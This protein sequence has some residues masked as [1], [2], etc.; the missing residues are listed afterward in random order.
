MKYPQFILA[1]LICLS[2]VACSTDPKTTDPIN[3]Q[4]KTP[5]VGQN[6]KA[7]FDSNTVQQIPARE[8]LGS[9]NERILRYQ[10]ADEIA[11]YVESPEAF[12]LYISKISGAMRR[13]IGAITP[14]KPTYGTVVIGI[15]PA[16]EHRLWYV[17]PDG[18]PSASLIGAIEAAVA[19]VPVLKV[20]K[21][22]AVFGLALTFWGYKETHEQAGRVIL[23]QEWQD[24]GKAFS[25]PQ[26]ATK[27]AQLAWGKKG[28]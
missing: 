5:L 26:K 22:V 15:N 14:E 7:P 3:T 12:D 28:A 24:A 19:E 16:G 8:I 1:A 25:Q 10:P 6:G 4:G 2:I 11:G 17:F 18:A 21:E 23:P 20:K 13:Q 27:L 9:K